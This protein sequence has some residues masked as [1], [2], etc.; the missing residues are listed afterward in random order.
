MTTTLTHR[1]VRGRQCSDHEATPDGRRLG[2]ATEAPDSLCPGCERRTGLQIRQQREF[3][4]LGHHCRCR[5]VERGQMELATALQ[6]AA[7][8]HVVDDQPAH[9]ARRVREELPATGKFR[10]ALRQIEVRL[11]QQRRRAQR[12]ARC[13]GLQLS[14]RQPMQLTV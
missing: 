12:G 13:I 1:C 10:L 5:G 7:F 9:R 3:G 6:S 8:A 11:V 4:R 2:A 14:L